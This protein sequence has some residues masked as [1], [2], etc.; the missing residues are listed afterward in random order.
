M[1]SLRFITSPVTKRL[2]RVLPWTAPFTSVPRPSLPRIKGISF[3]TQSTLEGATP[4]PDP[5]PKRNFKRSLLLGSSAAL[6]SYGLLYNHARAEEGREDKEVLLIRAI[7]DPITD[8]ANDFTSLFGLIPGIEEAINKENLR[9]FLNIFK[10]LFQKEPQLKYYYLLAEGLLLSTNPPVSLEI[11]TKAIQ[12]NPTHPLGYLVQGAL[13]TGLGRLKEALASYDQAIACKADYAEAYYNR[14]NVLNKLERPEDALASYDQAIACKRDYAVAYHN[15]GV[16]LGKLGRPEDAL[17][18]FDQVI[19]CKPDCAEAHCNRG[20]VLHDLDRPQ[21]ALASYDQAIVYKPEYAEAYV[22]RG[23]ALNKLGRPEDAL[24][25]FDQALVFKS[26]DAV[27]YYNRGRALDKLGRLEDALVSYSKAIVYKPGDT[28]AYYN[29]GVILNKLGRLEEALASYNQAIACKPDHVK[30]YVNRGSILDELGRPEDALASYDQAIIYEPDCVEAYVNRGNALSKLG[31]LED[32]LASYDQAIACKSND[33]EAYYSRGVT[34]NKLGRPEDALA[35]YNQAIAYKSDYAE[36]YYSRGVTLN[37][38]GRP[39]DA[40]ARV[41]YNRAVTL[42]KLNYPEDALTSYDQAIACKSDYAEA[43][44]NRGA[45]L[46]SLGRFENALLS[47]EQAI[48]Y[49]PDLYQPYI[50]AGIVF[51]ELGVYAYARQC[52]EEAIRLT[53]DQPTAKRLAEANLKIAE[54]LYLSSGKVWEEVKLWD[55]AVKGKDSEKQSAAVDYNTKLL[56]MARTEEQRYFEGKLAEKDLVL[57]SAI[58]NK[59]ALVL[60]DLLEQEDV[61][62][63]NRYNSAGKTPLLLAAQIGESDIVKALLKKGADADLIALPVSL[64]V[65]MGRAYET[66]LVA[67]CRQGHIDASIA[68]LEKYTPV[69]EARVDAIIEECRQFLYFDEGN[70][71]RIRHDNV[72]L[73]SKIGELLKFDVLRVRFS[74]GV[75]DKYQGHLDHASG[76]VYQTEL[77]G[78]QVS[79][80]LALHARFYLEILAGLKKSSSQDGGLLSREQEQL[81]KEFLLMLETA[82]VFYLGNKIV[83]GFQLNNKVSKEQKQA[84]VNAYVAAIAKRIQN[85][86]HE[87]SLASGY[88][89]HALYVNFLKHKKDNTL[90]T[91]IDNLGALCEEHLP[92]QKG[93]IYPCFFTTFP[94]GDQEK[95]KAYLTDNFSIKQCYRRSK[96]VG[97]N[98]YSLISSFISSLFRRVEETNTIEF[99]DVC[100][101]KEKKMTLKELAKLLYREECS[102]SSENSPP[103]S[104]EK[105]Q[106]DNCVT[107]NYFFGKSS[108]FN[109]PSL[110][111]NLWNR[112]KAHIT[113]L[114]SEE[115]YRPAHIEPPLIQ[116]SGEASIISSDAL[117]HPGLKK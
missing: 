19:I 60:A 35:S 6:I 106:V 77:A 85:A 52:F 68:L 58:E 10:K 83:E 33:A 17:A 20:A 48:R 5:K 14:G 41:Y 79:D 107:G 91:R 32:A 108:R 24:A 95:L 94:S 55:G 86:S 80:F 113:R 69:S 22:N 13:L 78:W 4:N 40:L 21:D 45:T 8:E 2:Q 49:K 50:G 101:P 102:G 99:I 16:M 36:A 57:H 9:E 103:V 11:T 81:K 38:L 47:Y 61:P 93:G 1:K 39:E 82:S 56:S 29:R 25:S 90:Y 46:A 84:V 7:T 43:Y 34:L 44:Y 12:I 75:L 92:A 67:A 23:N 72:L 66:P 114:S 42:G 30:A 100:N 73:D 26:D 116:E 28:A 112:E 64:A 117:Q 97:S 18:S 65:E 15:R 62:E 53:P 104:R 87:Y 88:D 70:E 89:G 37:E 105:Q 115:R 54:A 98:F 96:G 74:P 3:S 51:S 59:D 63:L 110:E 109:N 71:E 31:R 76:I 111:E 27:A